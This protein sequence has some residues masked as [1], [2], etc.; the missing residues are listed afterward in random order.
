MRQR[1]MCCRRNK[2]RSRYLERWALKN[3]FSIRQCQLQ[4]IA[5]KRE[6]TDPIQKLEKSLGLISP[7]STPIKPDPDA[8][9]IL[10]PSK[11]LPKTRKL[12]PGSEWLKFKRLTGNRRFSKRP[13][14]K[15]YAMTLKG[16]IQ[17]YPVMEESKTDQ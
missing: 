15:R 14:R 10:Q 16:V 9:Q 11:A 3:R 1:R 5:K 17:H 2:R 7:T 6:Q 4:R 8:M 13:L 12:A